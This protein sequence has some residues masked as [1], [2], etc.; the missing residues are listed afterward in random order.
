[1]LQPPL[2][3]LSHYLERNRAKYYDHLTATRQQRRDW[4]DRVCLF[5]RGFVKT[6]IKA[7]GIPRAILEPRHR[8]AA[9]Q[10]T[11]LIGIRLLD[12]LFDRSLVR[13]NLDVAFQK[14]NGD[15]EEPRLLTDITA[16]KR[17]LVFRSD[18][19]LSPLQENP[20]AGSR[21]TALQSTE[22]SG[23]STTSGCGSGIA[24]R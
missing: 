8:A 19:Y 4:E 3:Y 16:A 20:P 10:R 24:T 6:A 2:L 15:L 13:D 11:G 17:G 23:A 5:P 12:L 14:A 21:A 7:T 9:R 22:P 1:M 18:P